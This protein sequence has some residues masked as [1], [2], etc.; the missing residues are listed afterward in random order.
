LPL[1][2]AKFAASFSNAD[3]NPIKQV[4]FTKLPRHGSL[5]LNG[6]TLVACDKVFYSSLAKVSYLSILNYNGKDTIFWNA[7]DT[8]SYALS[9][10]SISLVITPVNDPPVITVLETDSLHYE[11]G[12]GPVTLTTEFQVIDVDNDSLASATLTFKTQNYQ[13]GYDF[14]SILKGT[15]SHITGSFD[16]DK[17]AISLSGKALI[18][19]YITIVRAVQYDLTKTSDEKI[20]TKG[21]S[22]T[23][24]DGT[25]DSQ[26]R[27]RYIT[28]AFSNVQ[29]LTI[30]TGFTPDGD[31][32]NDTWSI[33]LPG[34]AATFP[35]ASVKVYNKRGKVVFQ[36]TGLEK[37]WDG[38]FNGELLPADTYYFTVDL[39]LP[40]VKRTYHGP[41]TIL[42]R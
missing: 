38:T 3:G 9:D 5:Q 31:K 12:G 13:S 26:P 37:E 35:N 42:H 34:Q 32:I 11:V 25:D 21:V 40:Y 7:R 1:P 24:N 10:A 19:D 23:L 16:S 22:F 39:N 15:V 18:K 41:L 29:D 20:E 17:G 4:Q 6:K 33:A 14:L 2:A 30:P 36:S 27:V 8:L 28:L